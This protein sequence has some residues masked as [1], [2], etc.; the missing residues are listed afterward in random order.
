MPCAETKSP[1]LNVSGLKP[2]HLYKFEVKKNNPLCMSE[3]FDISILSK[4]KN[5]LKASFKEF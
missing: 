4:K 1:E 5:N 3:S 2:G